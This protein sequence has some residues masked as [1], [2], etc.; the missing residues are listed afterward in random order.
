MINLIDEEY[1]FNKLKKNKEECYVL[2]YSN[3]NNNYKKV[4]LYEELENIKNN[5]LDVAF[6][7]KNNNLLCDKIRHGGIIVSTFE[8]NKSDFNFLKKENNLFYY[9]KKRPI[10]Y[11][12]RLLFTKKDRTF[13]SQE[14]AKKYLNSYFDIV[15]EIDEKVNYSLIFMRDDETNINKLKELNI[16][17]TIRLDQVY[18]LVRSDRPCRYAI[19]KADNIIY[20][21]VYC[22]NEA[23][24][25]GV[26]RKKDS[27]INNGASPEFFFPTKE[28]N[29]DP[30]IFDE[31]VWNFRKGT[32]KIVCC[33]SWRKE[34]KPLRVF[35]L[36]D[37]LP[38]DYSLIFIGK[39]RTT[40]RHALGDLEK[41]IKEKAK[42]NNKILILGHVQHDRLGRI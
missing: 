27:I 23:L 20:Q 42:N 35:E 11:T 22:K 12:N 32:K 8:I 26:P 24:T 16:P 9:Q 37:S 33:S 40:Q 10:L 5:Y 15:Q 7:N 17:I 31:E 21:T 34:K 2:L 3:F 6:V 36:I 28:K 18:P 19:E 1:V 30:K 41:L 29:F 39:I 25:H 13:Q 4:L 38:D 14:Y